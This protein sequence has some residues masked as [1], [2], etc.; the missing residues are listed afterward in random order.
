MF[1]RWR[2]LVYLSVVTAVGL[3]SYSI[4]HDQQLPDIG[5]AAAGT[6]TIDQ[7]KIYG[8][9]YMRILRA[10]KPIIN[11]PV[12]SEFINS[13]GHRLVANADD[14][15]TP[16]TFFLIQDQSI[17][18]FAFFGGHVA[19]HTGLFLDANTESELASVMAHEI[20]H[21]TQRHLARSMEE[22][23]RRTPAT[24]AA[25]AG[26]LLLAIAAPQAGVAAITA[27][28]AGSMQSQI[29]YTRSNEIEADRFGLATLERAGFNV[30]AM[31]RFF[32]RL[33]DEYRYASKP[34][35][36]LLTHPLPDERI[37]D[38][39][40][41]AYRYPLH[42]VKPSL[43]YYLARVRVIV[44]YVNMDN[45]AA[46]GWINRNEKKAP[47]VLK[48]AFQYGHALL[49]LDNRQP[50]EAEKILDKLYL[51]DPTN[52]FYLDALSDTY[53]ALKQADKAQKMLEKALKVKPNNKVITINY[54]NVLIQEDKFEPA[55][56]LLQRYTHDNPEDVV[57]WQLLSESN[58]KAGHRAEELAAQ[59][60]LLALRANW[61]K[62]IQR[63][64][65]ASKIAKL[66]SLSQA[67]YDARIDQLILRRNQFNALK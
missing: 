58:G 29:N 28:T 7:E 63:Y 41:R 62:A 38:T 57:G 43:A 46:Q 15:K 39:R 12:L 48:P 10:S 17:N 8:D 30:R 9:A 60:E 40:I 34:P 61:D 59:G 5:T 45:D 65:E 22:R 52:D 67:R 33:A 4:A 54:A 25:L 16:F 49:Y 47:A 19:L 21:V 23:A 64:T 24:V 51:E 44:R 11:D 36:M 37:T 35:P 31:P 50:K 6:L 18:A 53:L 1:K 14:V 13:L 66:G 3:P 26:S 56:R 2:Y 42:K 27:T 20:A 32:G 55:I